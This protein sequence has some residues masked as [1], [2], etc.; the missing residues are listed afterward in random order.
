M[1]CQVIQ[2]IPFGASK[3]CI[4]SHESKARASSRSNSFPAL[5]TGATRV[6]DTKR[7][8]RLSY[9]RKSAPSNVGI[10]SLRPSPHC[11]GSLVTLTG[12]FHCGK[13][14]FDQGECR[15]RGATSMS[16]L[17]VSV[18]SRNSGDLGFSSASRSTLRH[19]MSPQHSWIPTSRSPVVFSLTQAA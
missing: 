10:T 1:C 18:N 11:R 5:L 14:W 12:D 6:L 16:T 13:S 19:P 9:C 17:A 8:T 15:S 2:Q 3:S 4:P 7:R